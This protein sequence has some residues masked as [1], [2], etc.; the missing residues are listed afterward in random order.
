MANPPDP[1]QQQEQQE[2]PA[3]VTQDE[4]ARTLNSAISSH[5]KRFEKSIAEMVATAATPKNET[6]QPK[7]E[8][9]LQI[10]RRKVEELETQRTK[11]TQALRAE[12]TDKRAR[13]VLAKAGV[14][15][16]QQK[17]ALAYL[18][19]NGMLSYDEEGQPVVTLK[20]KSA[21]GHVEDA[22]YGFDEG[23]AQWLKSDEAKPLLPA[24]KAAGP[25]VRAAGALAGAA[26]SKPPPLGQQS[27]TL[28]ERQRH[29]AIGNAVAA[30]MASAD[31]E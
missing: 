19:R 22:V 29:E 20:G 13:E 16:P 4:L 6:A 17:F 30:S 3:Y 23:L 12:R 8:S 7:N 31:I 15:E 14:S 27:Q 18:E 5:M 2:A 28:T 21:A 24:P 9:E 11:D 25:T 10:L 26:G 1:T